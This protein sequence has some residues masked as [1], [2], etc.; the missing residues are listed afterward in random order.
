V[1]YPHGDVPELG[2]W[3]VGGGER[4]GGGEAEAVLVHDPVGLGAPGRAAL[5]ED[6]R[7]LDADAL[8]GGAVVDGL[9]GAG[10]LPVAGARRAVGADAVGVLAVARAEEVVLAVAV[11]GL[12]CVSAARRSSSIISSVPVQAIYEAAG[13]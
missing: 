6:E 10:G 8:A 7:L 1:T 11:Q 3:A 5:V 12:G 4:V 9:V 13:S 2:R